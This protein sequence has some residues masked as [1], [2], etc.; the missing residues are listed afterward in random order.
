MCEG[1][2]APWETDGATV[3]RYDQMLSPE[4]A[5]PLLPS[6][7][8][9][10]VAEPPMVVRLAVTDT[11]ELVGLV[12][13]VTVTVSRVWQPCATGDVAVAP[14]PVGCVIPV[15]PFTTIE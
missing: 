15:P 12:P 2:R 11:P 8:I 13:L 5:S 14:D 6:L 10:C 9:C 7:N 3:A 1:V 4:V